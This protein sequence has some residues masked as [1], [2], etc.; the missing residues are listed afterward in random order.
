MG[1]E[2]ISCLK[3]WGINKIFCVTVDNASSNDVALLRLKSCF[4]EKKNG[5]VLGG[6]MLHMR[7]CAHILNLIDCD[8]LKEISHAISAIRNVVRF[9]RSSPERLKRFKESYKEEN[10]ES[11]AL[12]CLYVTS[13]WNSTYSMLQAATKFKKSFVVLERDGNYTNY[14]NEDMSDGRNI[15]GLPTHVDWDRAEVFVRFLRTFYEMTLKFS[16]SK[17]VTSNSFF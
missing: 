1:N 5:L 8:G 17:Y 15:N 11:R 10:I 7:C 12:L 3:D 16:G 14:F 4:E 2:L 6:E 9:V 13:R